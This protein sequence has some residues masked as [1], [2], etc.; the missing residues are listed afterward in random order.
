MERT[1]VFGRE[2][3][4]QPMVFLSRRELITLAVVP[5]REARMTMQHIGIILSI[6]GTVLLAFSV[7]VKRQ[8]GGEAAKAVDAAKLRD[9]SLVEPTETTI[10]RPLFW[11]G[12]ALIALGSLL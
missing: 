11:F 5:P 7:K 10:V 8:Y 12:L 1:V 2:S 4:N 6:I 3:L 9:P